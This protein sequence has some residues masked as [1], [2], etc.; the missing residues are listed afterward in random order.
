MR[1]P[2]LDLTRTYRELEDEIL[3]AVE[4]L[5]RSQQMILGPAVHRFEQSLAA[6]CGSMNRR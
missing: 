1:V 4:K 2:L 3:R 5:L 6:L